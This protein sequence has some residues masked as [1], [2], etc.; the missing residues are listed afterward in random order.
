MEIKNENGTL[1]TLDE[2]YDEAVEMMVDALDYLC[3][4]DQL[5]IS[6]AYREMNNYETL[7]END[8]GTLNSELN[9]VNPYE[10]LKLGE[11][12]CHSDG[13]FTWDGWDLNTTDDV[14]YDIEQKDIAQAIL[15][16]NLSVRDYRDLRDVVDEY[17]EMKDLLENYNPLRAEGVD[18]LAKYVDG[19]ADVTDLLQYIDRLVKN[20][21]VWEKE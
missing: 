21:E 5:G 7:Y 13:Y 2:L 17:E 14:W 15:D 10:L 16:G 19:K 11:D 6:N 12:W 4:D 9:G 18:L 8:E 1:K 3:S 20:D